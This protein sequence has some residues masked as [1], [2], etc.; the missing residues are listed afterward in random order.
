MALVI[1]LSISPAAEADQSPAGCAGTPPTV[2]FGSQTIE[3][4]ETPAR[5]G[6]PIVLSARITNQGDSACNLSGLTVRVR[7]PGRDGTPS[8][9]YRTLTSNTFLAAGYGVEG[10]TEVNP[11]VVDLDDG[12]F[13]APLEISWHAQ[14]H[15][16][17]QNSTVSGE[18]VPVK[19][20]LTRPRTS[21]VVK[22]SPATGVSP[23]LATTT[24]AL[25]NTSP[26]PTTGAAAPGLVPDG[27]AGLRDLIADASCGPVVYLS[28]DGDLGTE[29]GPV[30]D[31][32]ETWRFTC[33]RTY[34]LPGTYSSQPTISGNS[35]VDGRPWPQPA[36]G[37]DFA[38]VKVL[39]PDL[40][41]DK[42]HQGDLLAGGT[43]EYK[44]KV[45]NSGNQPTSGKVVVYDLLPGGLTATA[46][47]GKGWNCV[48]GSLS[49]NRSDPLASGLSFPDVTVAVRVAT[50]PPSSVTNSA[51]VSG[52]GEMAGATGNNADDDPTT[53]RSPGQ[54]QM[55]TS[56]R[57]TVGK[58]KSRNDGSVAIP[59]TVPGRGKLKIDDASGP[60]LVRKA[61]KQTGAYGSYTLVAKV[62]SR[63]YRKLKR[64]GGV[65]TIKLKV[66]FKPRGGK[67]ASKRRQA[68]FRVR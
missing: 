26:T 15:N 27:P 38:Q 25:T 4:L 56:S 13:E 46:I 21:L 14:V 53:I 7:L 47:S 10:F 40:V 30:L 41:V 2:T 28:G 62:R 55:P 29:R 59:V 68:R 17:D 64:T 31:P 35:D 57:F 24:Y 58:P 54:P 32:G 16:G 67:S 6:D 33:T 18:G 37:T 48:L 45:T 61:T 23:L 50:S 63:L 66:T 1:A 8:A 65:R 12:V 49:C 22:S 42:S 34:L 9:S 43:G 3:Q 20:S 52:G 5:Q 51:K 44:L 19:L 11:Y 39:G 60:D 36:A